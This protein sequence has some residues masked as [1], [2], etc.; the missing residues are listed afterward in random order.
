MGIDDGC[1]GVGCIVKAIHELKAEG[2]QQR[3]AQQDIWVEGRAS[4]YLQIPGEAD[5]RVDQTNDES[6]PEDGNANLSGI[7]RH[8]LM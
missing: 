7:S 3:D 4:F 2:D 6:R 5:D 1:N 8:F